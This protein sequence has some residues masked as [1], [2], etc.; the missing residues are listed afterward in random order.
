MRFCLKKQMIEIFDTIRNENNLLNRWSKNRFCMC[1]CNYESF[2]QQF[3]R[4]SLLL[5]SIS[6]IFMIYMFSS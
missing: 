2:E 3:C 4:L 5:Y 6:E 1:I